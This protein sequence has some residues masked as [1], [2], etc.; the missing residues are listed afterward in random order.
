VP[1]FSIFG[2]VAVAGAMFVP[3]LSGA[4]AASLKSVTTKENKTVISLS[5]EIA[6]GDADALRKAIQ[7]ANDSG[8]LVSGVRLNS[9]GGLLVEAVK[10]VDLIKYAKVVTVVSNGSTC[11]SACFVVFAAGANKFASYSAQVGVHGASGE[12]GKETVGSGAATVTMARIV[13]DLGVPAPI[14]GK[15]VVTPPEQMVWLTPDELRSMGTT[16]TGKPAQ[17]ASPQVP[18]SEAP[19]QLDPSARGALPPRQ[20][21]PPNNDPPTW[22]KAFRGAV[23]TSA[24]QNGGKPQLNRICQPEVKLCNIAVFFRWKDGK[25]GMLR[26]TEDLSGKVTAREVCTFNDFSDIRECFNWDTGKTRKD[27]K[28]TKG[29]WYAVDRD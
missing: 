24:E 29:E 7:T 16:M 3:V 23:A 8:K 20:T 14:I 10:L 1:K 12:D 6:E 22:D 26:Q 18:S 15:M 4:D 19:M 11:A 2:R 21:P 28:N 27:M 17:V 9:P 13:R 5:G 25:D